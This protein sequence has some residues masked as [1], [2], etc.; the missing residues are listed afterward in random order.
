MGAEWIHVDGRLDMTNLIVGFAIFA[1]APKK[2][3]VAGKRHRFYRNRTGVQE[4]ISC[5]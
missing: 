1:T 4:R 2:L 5:V 3:S